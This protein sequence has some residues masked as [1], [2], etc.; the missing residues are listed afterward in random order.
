[1]AIERKTVVDQV[2]VTRNGDL[3]IRIALLIV[4]GE[5]EI[6]S[7]WHRTMIPAGH[8]VDPQMALVNH[9]LALMGEET[10]KDEDIAKIKRIQASL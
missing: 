4:D 8:Q 10:V 3:Q 2:E 6:G 1:M 7:K 5:K 9:H